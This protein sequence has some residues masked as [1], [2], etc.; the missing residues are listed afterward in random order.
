MGSAVLG[1]WG[2]GR[3]LGVGGFVESAERGVVA[4]ASRRCGR[5][6][7]R[8]GARRL[9]TR[10]ARGVFRV[11]RADRGRMKG[12]EGG[13]FG[14][15]AVR[16]LGRAFRTNLSDPALVGTN[17]RF[18]AFSPTRVVSFVRTRQSIRV[19]ILCRLAP[20]CVGYIH[21]VKLT[22][23]GPMDSRF[24]SSMATFSTGLRERATTD[25]I[26]GEKMLMG[27]GA[28]VTLH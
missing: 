8:F 22:F 26:T 5:G 7:N 14:G 12:V 2:L 17:Y 19:D 24:L 20:C 10:R 1:L 27:C 28:F 21:V 23:G 4:V 9:S 25:D 15:N 13:V 6:F 18:I 16:V 3:G 11:F